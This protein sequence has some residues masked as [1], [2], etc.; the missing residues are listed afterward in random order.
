MSYS[1]LIRNASNRQSDISDYEQCGFEA[2]RL[3]DDM[4]MMVDKDAPEDIKNAASDAT[5]GDY[6]A[7]KL[8]MGI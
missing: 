6:D 2:Y 3:P 8:A 7:Y 1:I 4:V 5:N